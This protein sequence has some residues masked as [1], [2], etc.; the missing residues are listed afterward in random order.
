M[1]RLSGS[2]FLELFGR[3]RVILFFF[4]GW[5][6]S[7]FVLA[8]FLLLIMEI[9]EGLVYFFLKVGVGR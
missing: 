7:V 8:G 5:G 6:C 9:R 2:Y 4:V 3:I 1:A